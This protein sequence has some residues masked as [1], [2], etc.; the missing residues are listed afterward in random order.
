[1]QKIV[2]RIPSSTDINSDA[3]CETAQPDS[4]TGGQN[5]TRARTA[6][7]RL[8]SQTCNG[9]QKFEKSESVLYGMQTKNLKNF[10]V[11]IYIDKDVI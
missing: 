6:T 5:L 11:G 3:S 2:R 8:C 4:D 7:E 1:M 9:P 10:K